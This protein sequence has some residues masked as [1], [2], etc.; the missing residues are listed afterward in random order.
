MWVPSKLDWKEKEIEL[1]QETE[2]PRVASSSIVIRKGGRFTLHIRY[3]TWVN[4]DGF[5]VTVNGEALQTADTTPGQYFAID[6]VWQAGDRVDVALPTSVNAEQ[7]PDGENYYA[8]LYGP[9]ALAAASNP[10]PGEKLQYFADDSRMG[11]AAS[12]QQCPLQDAP[13]FISESPDF[14]KGIRRITSGDLIFELPESLRYNGSEKLSLKPF[15]ETHE[16]RYTLYFPYSTQHQYDQ[17]KQA[18]VAAEEKHL[19]L[20]AMTIDKVT[21]GEQQP[22]SDHFFEGED[23]EAGVYRNKHWRHATG[24]FSY[25]LRDPK[26]EAKILRIT[27]NGLDKGRDFDIKINGQRLAAVILTGERGDQLFTVDYS[28]ANIKPKESGVL[29]VKFVAAPNSIAGGIFGLRLL[30]Q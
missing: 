30:R 18:L 24:W 5:R 19:A 4:A 21:P 12:G 22:E 9:I 20:E 2:F 10:F 1:E 23:T 11:H 29:D 16:T 28:L 25:K 27:Y 26:S 6:R 14:D 3:P 13:R 15:Y 7:L 8:L 17:E